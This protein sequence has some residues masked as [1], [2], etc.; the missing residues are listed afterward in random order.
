M[1]FGN[2]RQPLGEG[3]KER[4]WRNYIQPNANRKLLQI[5]KDEIVTDHQN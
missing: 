3:E 5:T 1:T 4:N 2:M